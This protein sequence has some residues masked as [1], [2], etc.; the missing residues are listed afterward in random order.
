M[1]DGNSGWIIFT[2]MNIN[3]IHYH[4]Y[5]SFYQAIFCPK[6][7]EGSILVIYFLLDIWTSIAHLWLDAELL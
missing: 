3:H 7:L 4:E 6:R 2:I 5:N 1:S